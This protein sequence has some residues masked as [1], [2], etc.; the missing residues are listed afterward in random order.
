MWPRK[1]GHIVSKSGLADMTP[2]RGNFASAGKR[3]KPLSGPP[4]ASAATTP[5]SKR[6][7]AGPQKVS[8]QTAQSSSQH[9]TVSGRSNA[10]PSNEVQ[11]P[12]LATD[13]DIANALLNLERE[14]R[15]A[16]TEAELGFLMVNGSRV[17]V[18]Y[19]QALLLLRSGPD[20]YRVISV[21]SLSAIDRNS[22]FIRWVERLAKEKLAGDNV[23]KVLSFDAKREAAGSDLDASSYPFSQIAMVPLQLRDGTVFGHL[24]FTRE[25]PWEE[26]SLVAAARL[27]ETYSHAWE[28][29]TGPTRVKKKL[30]SRSKLFAGIGVAML[31]AGFFPVPLS[32]LAPAE[33]T[34][35]DPFVV[36]APIDGTVEN[37][38]VD[39]N[40]F[41]KKGQL[42][43]TY[44]D[45][46]LRNR[47]KLAGQ[48][49]SVAEA[50]YQQSLRTSFADVSAK[51][52]LSI[53]QSELALKASEYDY[54]KDLLDKSQVR[55]K[56]SGLVIF[57][58]KESW[59]G[60]PVATG[61]RIMR[62]AD[63][64]KVELK[65]DLPVADS[66]V[67]Q[68]EASIQLYL[69]SAPLSAIGATVTRASFHARPDGD[70]V[71]SY[72][73][74][75]KFDHSQQTPRIGLRGTAK[76]YGESVSL[77]YFVFRK[78]ISAIRQ[79]TGY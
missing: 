29:L 16:A 50:R 22:T 79:W 53:A 78:P 6:Q 2:K 75:A 33:V 13:K 59:T 34:A 42:L 7:T 20:K 69:D 48:A 9:A 70:G 73:V 76:V 11:K 35:S 14:A 24:M 38:G 51:R 39:P 4:T 41:V 77:A 65:V 49:V 43:F 3:E 44:N 23:G 31:L 5:V 8:V 21:S 57:A 36:A 56:R 64:A 72:R 68:N 1:R 17:A 19:R 60:R 62:I 67:L 10:R 32:V 74:A 18:Q 45:T 55:A 54:A 12:A 25:A 37:V 15:K 61:E 58:D 63:P 26:T 52:E 46:E 71:L 27:C 47:L 66:I 28:A 30:Q 40:S